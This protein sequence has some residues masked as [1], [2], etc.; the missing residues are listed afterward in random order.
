MFNFWFCFYCIQ[1]ESYACLTCACKS[2]GVWHNTCITVQCHAFQ[3]RILCT[4]VFWFVWMWVSKKIHVCWYL[5]MLN[6][7]I[8]RKSILKSLRKIH[9]ILSDNNSVACKT[10]KFIIIIINLFI[11]IMRNF[12]VWAIPS[13]GRSRC[14][15]WF[16]GYSGTR[17]RGLYIHKHFEIL[18]ASIIYTCCNQII[19]SLDFI[20]DAFDS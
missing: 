7:L 13:L 6:T 19:P 14:L 20:N 12:M 8:K 10:F 17:P 9:K 2:L 18:P 11:I 1:H 15:Q 16:L 5:F 4:H 3:T